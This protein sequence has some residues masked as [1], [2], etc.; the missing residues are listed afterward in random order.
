M[1]QHFDCTVALEGLKAFAATPAAKFCAASSSTG[2]VPL[3]KQPLRAKEARIALILMHCCS[4]STALNSSRH[5]FCANPGMA[6][7]GA[8][9]SP[10]P[11]ASVCAR[12]G[13]GR[14]KDSSRSRPRAACL[15]SKLCGLA[16]A[17]AL[18]SVVWSTRRVAGEAYKAWLRLPYV[19]ASNSEE[20]QPNAQ[21]G[22]PKT[23]RGDTGL[24]ERVGRTPCRLN[25]KVV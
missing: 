23:R 21:E 7:A 10:L 4:E 14:I 22:Q 13:G 8:T 19:C 12:T 1:A 5:G 11:C 25:T 20:G 24:K 3:R 16:R 15:D 17:I 6:P 2:L 9:T 18:K